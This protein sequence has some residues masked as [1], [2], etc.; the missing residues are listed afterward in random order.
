MSTCID[1]K[2][3]IQFA[4]RKV[5]AAKYTLD[6][7]TLVGRGQFVIELNFRLFDRLA[8]RITLKAF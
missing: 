2:V 5:D 3:F 1:I 8:I 4:F 6:F 7:Q